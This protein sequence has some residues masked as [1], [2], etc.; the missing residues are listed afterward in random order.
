[1]NSSFHSFDTDILSIIVKYLKNDCVDLENL[2]LVQ[3]K[4]LLSK[5]NKVLSQKNTN[6]KL[7]FNHK[8]KVL[9]NVLSH[10][11]TL[12]INTKKITCFQIFW[13]KLFSTATNT[14]NIKII[15]SSDIGDKLQKLALLPKLQKLHIDS[16]LDEFM[17]PNNDIILPNLTTL[18][19]VITCLPR[20]DFAPNLVDL[21]VKVLEQKDDVTTYFL[22][23]MPHL[24][25]LM[26]VD[27]RNEDGVYE[28]EY[29]Y[30]PHVTIIAN[31]KL[32]SFSAKGHFEIHPNYCETVLSDVSKI[33]IDNSTFCET[34]LQS[35][36]TLSMCAPPFWED[37]PKNLFTFVNLEC[38]TLSET[39]LYLNQISHLPLKTLNLIDVR[40]E[41]LDSIS[42]FP[43]LESIG[44]LYCRFRS[45]T[46]SIVEVF[47]SSLTELKYS[48]Y[49][50]TK[51]PIDVDIKLLPQ[52]KYI[53]IEFMKESNY[54]FHDKVFKCLKRKNTNIK[55]VTAYNCYSDSFRSN[56]EKFKPYTKVVCTKKSLNEH[57]FWG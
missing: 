52:L 44:I 32:E 1:M 6:L 19:V 42:K 14:S 54:P 41:N 13:A 49:S 11:S 16:D 2:I 15:N 22:D 23:R 30:P 47:P 39:M 36:K 8:S 5:L 55:Q 18:Y 25:H 28:D 48:T 7:K 20:F 10:V 26:F 50:H 17:K 40:V 27:N 43:V 12:M 29:D 57:L 33:A 38:L 56:L 24:K 51:N 9:V 3:N 37:I 53:S 46:D 45:P 35:L 4:I 31:C 21:T 34:N